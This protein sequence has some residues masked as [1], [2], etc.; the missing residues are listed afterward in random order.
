MTASAKD[1]LAISIATRDRINVVEQTLQRI[2]EFGLGECELIICDDGSSPALQVP[3][4]CRFPRG[5]LIRNDAPVG[6]AVARNQIA[7]A[8]SRPFIL[9]LDDDSYPVAGIVEQL[10][11][12]AREQNDWLAMALPLEEPVRGRRAQLPKEPLTGLR[13]F[14][15]CA[16]LINRAV[17]LQLGGYAD[18]IGGM[19]E[20][21]ELSLR[22]F[23][24]G[25]QVYANGALQIR[26]DVSPTAR[27][28]GGIEYR[29]FRNWT[30]TW[31]RHAPMPEVI[32]R[33]TRLFAASLWK[34]VSTGRTTALRG[35]LDA[36]GNLRRSIAA[37][38]P[39]ARDCYVAYLKTPHA[40]ETLSQDAGVA[41]SKGA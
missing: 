35:V 23:A 32:V 10:L 15:G 12:A 4:L 1:V 2:E 20:E 37:R 27:N 36:L 8:A 9:Q 3:S 39:M 21:D 41:S 25:Y 22:G 30:T 5:R 17:F 29:S 38:A 18:W 6:Q 19:V 16:A 13:S 26:H 24:S 7:A 11:A 34:F 33:V 31:L 28:V 14:V 40:L